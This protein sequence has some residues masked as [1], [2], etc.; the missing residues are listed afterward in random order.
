MFA[1]LSVNEPKRRTRRCEI[2]TRQVAVKGGAPF[3]VIS[4]VPS[5]KGIDWQKVSLN[6]GCCSRSIVLAKNVDLPPNSPL[7]VFK[8]SVLPL[9][10]MLNS[11]V[12]FASVSGKPFCSSALIVD[13]FAVL[14][15]YVHRLVPFAAK[16]RVVTDNTELYRRTAGELLNEYGFAL[17]TER[18]ID[19]NEK[20]DFAVAEQSVKNARVNFACE[21]IAACQLDAFSD[22]LKLCPPDT[23]RLTFLSAL[24]EC[25]GVKKIGERR[26]D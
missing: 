6:C 22:Y 20:F 24:F 19:E 7:V 5:K 2:S 26:L 9:L 15:D 1:V 14:A 12:Q 4:V 21:K 23:D 18:C 13:R 17:V 8:P 3:R 16:I 10:L 25:C 11:A